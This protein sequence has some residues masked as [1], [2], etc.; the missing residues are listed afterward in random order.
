[1]ETITEMSGSKTGSM[2]LF[3]SRFFSSFRAKLREIGE[4]LGVWHPA[5][6][7]RH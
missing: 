1:M 7:T 2:D 5:N 6:V 3:L 4:C